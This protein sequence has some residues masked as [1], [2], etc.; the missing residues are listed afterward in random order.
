MIAY[1]IYSKPFNASFGMVGASD[2]G[3]CNVSYSEWTGWWSLGVLA[4]AEMSLLVLKS[5]HRAAFIAEI[6][7]VTLYWC[8]G[9]IDSTKHFNMTSLWMCEEMF[10]QPL[11][12]S[13]CE[14]WRWPEVFW[15][16]HGFVFHCFSRFHWFEFT[17]MLS[18][19]SSSNSVIL[20]L[21]R[22]H[23]IVK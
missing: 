12:S 16:F 5:L 8:V 13:R 1:W 17:G 14:T 10:M 3:R 18:S 4:E 19:F 7:V 15:I 21:V 20:C 6:E 9:C 11:D 22:S 2:F 23:Q